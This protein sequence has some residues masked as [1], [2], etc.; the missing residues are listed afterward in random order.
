M[1]FICFYVI[2]D[3]DSILFFYH[4]SWV[5]LYNFE[6]IIFFLQGYE[7]VNDLWLLYEKE[8]INSEID[9]SYLHYLFNIHSIF[10]KN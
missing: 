10:G 7:I 8:G 9:V 6:H 4:S 1:E 5:V 2:D 3:S